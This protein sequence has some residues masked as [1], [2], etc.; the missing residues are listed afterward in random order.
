MTLKMGSIHCL[1][2]GQVAASAEETSATATAKLNFG[3]RGGGGALI[4]MMILLLA[5]LS[6]GGS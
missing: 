3:G 5:M 2:S 4:M 1:K 6:A